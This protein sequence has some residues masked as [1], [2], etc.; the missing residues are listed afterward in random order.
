MYH[1]SHVRSI[2]NPAPACIDGAL[3]ETSAT[4]SILR[5]SEIYLK[6]AGDIKA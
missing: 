3:I 1:E 2:D 5:H 6:I 4:V